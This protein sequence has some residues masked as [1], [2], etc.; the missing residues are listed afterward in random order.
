MVC[1]S[2]DYVTVMVQVVRGAGG[3][4]LSYDDLLNTPYTSARQRPCCKLAMKIE[5]G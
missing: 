2:K 3:C 1:K 4:I 5:P